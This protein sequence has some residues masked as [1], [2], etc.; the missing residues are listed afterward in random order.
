MSTNTNSKLF[1]KSYIHMLFLR[2]STQ[3]MNEFLNIETM[4]TNL[5]SLHCEDHELLWTIIIYYHFP[6]SVTL[7]FSERSKI[8]TRRS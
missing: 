6:I 2:E 3:C 4:S 5:P 8:F 1:F 7:R